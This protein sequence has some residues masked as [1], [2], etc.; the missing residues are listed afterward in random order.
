[1]TVPKAEKNDGYTKN[2]ISSVLLMIFVYKKQISYFNTHIW[3]IIKFCCFATKLK[4]KNNNMENVMPISTLSISQ[5][6][7]DM[8]SIHAMSDAHYRRKQF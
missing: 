3:P 2:Y 7:G 1:M 8:V 4:L 5:K 6:Y